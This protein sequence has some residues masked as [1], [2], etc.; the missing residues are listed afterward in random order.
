MPYQENPKYPQGTYPYASPNPD[1]KEEKED[2]GRET[3]V[4]IVT[5]EKRLSSDPNVLQEVEQAI[6]E[7]ALT[8]PASSIDTLVFKN[9][10]AST[11]VSD[12]T[13]AD[14]SYKCVLALTG[15]TEDM[16][17]E[18]V[19]AP[20]EAMSGNYAPVCLSGANSVTIYGKVNTS[21]TIPLV[22]ESI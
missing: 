3:P 20:T 14:F 4:V 15:V 10:T 7:G 21:I 2:G 18:V 6:Q 16:F 1:L 5:D 19:F 13:Y 22:K 8:I 9:V 12:N 11:W 17:I